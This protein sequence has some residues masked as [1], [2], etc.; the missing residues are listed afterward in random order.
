[1][2]EEWLALSLSNPGEDL[3]SD[4][5]LCKGYEPGHFIIHTKEGDN[6]VQNNMQGMPFL[7]IR[8]LEG[9]V[10]LCLLQ[11][12]IDTVRKTMEGFSKCEVGEAKAACEAQ[13]MLGHPTNRKFLG[14]VHSH[15]ISNYNVTDTAIHNADQIFG[16]DLAGVRGRTVRQPPDHVHIDYVQVTMSIVE[17]FRVVTLT[18]DCMFVNGVPFLV[19]AL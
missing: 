2:K 19:S 18:V 14:M 3:A 1:M 10:A 13:A 11:N 8:E 12:T 7:D 17:R 5:Q 15:M 4:I 6:V 9:E 16:P